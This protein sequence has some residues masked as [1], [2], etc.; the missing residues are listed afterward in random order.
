MARPQKAAKSSP[1]PPKA[2]RIR[3]PRKK[4]G[5]EIGTEVKG[6]ASASPDVDI[7]PKATKRKIAL[8][9]TM[10]PPAKRQK[11]TDA[12]PTEN[13][14]KPTVTNPSTPKKTGVIP[15]EPS[16]PLFRTFPETPKT[17]SKVKDNAMHK[18][19][20]SDS[21]LEP[22]P[23]AVHTSSSRRLK[24][25]IARL[26][27]Q[28]K[29]PKAS[30]SDAITK[31]VVKEKQQ[32]KAICSP[33]NARSGQDCKGHILVDKEAYSNLMKR[34]VKVN[35]M[36]LTFTE[37]VTNL[38]DTDIDKNTALIDL[39]A[40]ARSLSFGVQALT[41]GMAKLPVAETESVAAVNEVSEETG[42]D[43]VSGQLPVEE[44]AGGEADTCTDLP[45]PTKRVVIK[46]PKKV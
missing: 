41:S 13:E 40:E 17:P 12:K 9:P 22:Q 16:K 14:T 23:M 31:N 27:S 35:K 34:T 30:M 46:V 10:S 6:A 2:R 25:E 20:E 33:D 26:K 5:P 8:K 3:A 19:D 15:Q 36:V 45:T 44:T 37:S 18:M 11:T 39:L 7:K 24:A 4:T 29:K 1:A 32:H 21:D 43:S 28:I 42:V 38:D